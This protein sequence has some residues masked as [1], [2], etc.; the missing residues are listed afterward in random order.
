MCLHIVAYLRVG[1]SLASL[2]SWWMIHFAAINFQMELFCDRNSPQAHKLLWGFYYII[3]IYYCEAIEC[4]K[5]ITLWF[6]LK[7]KHWNKIPSHKF[8]SPLHKW[9]TLELLLVRSMSTWYFSL[10]EMSMWNNQRNFIQK[11]LDGSFSALF[12]SMWKLKDCV[13]QQFIQL[14][15]GCAQQWVDFCVCVSLL[16]E[17]ILPL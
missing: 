8:L 2:W 6:L 7:Q 12:F 10:C 3:I 1:T 13:V 11:P 15:S 16:I 4:R 14:C 17:P 5:R 9:K